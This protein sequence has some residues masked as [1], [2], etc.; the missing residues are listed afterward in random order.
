MIA[1]AAGRPLPLDALRD[2]AL[3]ILEELRHDPGAVLATARYEQ[4][5]AWTFGHTIRVA[6]LAMLLADAMEAGTEAA[7]RI[8]TAAM[9]HDIGKA[10]LPFEILHARG[11]LNAEQRRELMQHT[12]YGA[13]ILLAQDGV[14][15]MVVG[16]AFG[17]HLALQGR[18]YPRTLLDEPISMPTRIVKICDVFE[19]LTGPRPHKPA[20]SA[21]VAFRTMLAMRDHF[22]P[23]LLRRFI[24]THGIHPVGRCVRLSSGVDARVVRQSADLRAPI[25]ALD[26]GGEQ[27]ELDLS[28]PDRRPVASCCRP[29]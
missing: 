19:G 29:G 9:L 17:H 4:S 26:V 27:R 1:A 21:V 11:W 20:L 25:V 5:D 7:Q 15:P 16:V 2:V 14:D 18:G 12:V 13:E 3:R 28:R 6:V 23:G 22:D 24:E 8:G 10:R